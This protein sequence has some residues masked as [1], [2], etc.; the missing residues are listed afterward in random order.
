M[1]EGQSDSQSDSHP[2]AAS[3]PSRT[4]VLTHLLIASASWATS[5]LFIKLINGEMSPLALAS[6]RAII[7]TLGLLPIIMWLGQSILPN[8]REW[9]DWAI[10]GTLN[11]WVP[12][13]LVVFALERMDTGPAALI[14]ASGP[15]M[16]ALLAHQFLKGERLNGARVTGLVIGMIGVATLIGPAAL[17]G[18]ASTFGVLAMLA[19]TLCYAVANIY[20]RRI[21]VADPMRLALG[22]QS[23]SAVFA[24]TL[25]LLTV[26][27]AGFAPA[28][29]HVWTLLG[30]GLIA[31]AAPIA[32]FMR[33]LRA[34]GP[35][36]ASMTGYLV[37]TF[38]IVIGVT[39]LGETLLARQV[40]G[41]VIVLCGVAI[42]TGALRL[43][44]T[45]SQL[46]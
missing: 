26:G 27:S 38:A 43:P 18:G 21:P 42:V 5:F 12:N 15:L 19:L 41:G 7:G 31:T 32:L 22:Q 46:S 37:P 16:N 20:V 33:L 36:K 29:G 13:I 6:L 14:Q 23:F 4:F 10:I 11:G 28:S 1:S 9:R 44:F 8:G 34:A 24:T 39:I 17:T 45:K 25:A 40:I 3:V 30:L 2:S 35:A